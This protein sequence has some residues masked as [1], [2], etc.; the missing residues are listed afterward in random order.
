MEA[1]MGLKG[2]AQAELYEDPLVKDTLE[3]IAA[4][5]TIQQLNG[6]EGCCRYIISH[7]SSALNVLEVMGLFLLGGW[8]KKGPDGRYHPFVRDRG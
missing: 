1:L 8:T 7:S 2:G 4:I 3:T 6:E 5:R